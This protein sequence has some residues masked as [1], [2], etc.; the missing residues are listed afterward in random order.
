M[1]SLRLS[2]SDIPRLQDKVAIITGGTSG[3][4][5]ATARILAS[6]GATVHVLDLHPIRGDDLDVNGS[7]QDTDG[8]SASQ[9]QN[10]E[11]NKRDDDNAPLKDASAT[12][13]GPIHFHQC[14]I[15]SFDSLLSFFTSIGHIDIAVANAGVSQEGDY[16]ADTFGPDG[17][18]EEPAYGVIDV[19]YR[20]VL[21][22]VKLSMRAFRQQQQQ[23]GTGGGSIVITSSATAY[24]PEQSLPVYSAT[25]LALVGLVR[26]LRST[27]HLSGATINAVAPAAT[28]TRL[29]PQDLASPIMAAGAPVSS[30]DHVALAIVYSATATQE[31]AVE[32]YGKDSDEKIDSKGRWNGRVILTLGDTWTE[33][34]EPI[35]KLKADWMGEY[36]SKMTA[37]Q[38]RLTDFR[39]EETL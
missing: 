23:E 20:A 14:D 3:I 9:R 19:N 22:F 25:K 33:V 15:T 13:K 12:E 32:R 8:L 24:S 7:Q 2:I 18:L 1:T 4:G 26:A 36:V 29:L 28:I 10:E 37:F 11:D 35:A 21:N 31:H 27:I 5:L 39:P 16:F 30:A 17:T 38:Q 34:E 6:R